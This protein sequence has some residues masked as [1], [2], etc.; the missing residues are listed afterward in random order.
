M[1]KIGVLSQSMRLPFLVLTPACQFLGWSV[2]I[3]G[4]DDFDVHLL[5]LSLVAGILA[6]ISVNTLN[7]YSD[8]RS[9]L[10]LNTIKTPF[11]GGSGAL[12]AHPEMAKNV[13]LLGVACLLGTALTGFYF[14]YLYGWLIAPLGIA[15]LLLI[16]LY[17]DWFN[18]HP[19]L[20]LLAP[21]AG[22]GLLMVTGSAF[23]LTGEYRVA[24]MLLSLVSFF[25]VNNLLLLNQY[26][27]VEAD[28]TAGRN[29]LLIAYGV[30]AASRVYLLFVLLTAVSIAAAVFTNYIPVLSLLSLLLLPLAFFSYRGATIYG[31][32][33]G[34]HPQYLASNVVI[35]IL[36]PV[37]LGVLIIVG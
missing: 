36:L 10:D 35:S 6:H 24:A 26:P 37:L 9:G 5:V 27:D 33:I 17:T 32:K 7:E 12:P 29:H 20:C 28:R 30:K 16:V 21:G 4:N 31:E 25:L 23:A 14:I 2:V 34:E 19:L 3:A 11:S 13:L 22:F 8:F 15:G 18:K 1:M